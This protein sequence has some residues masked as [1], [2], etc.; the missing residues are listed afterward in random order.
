MQHG[1]SLMRFCHLLVRVGCLWKI[2]HFLELPEEKYFLF[3]K[4]NDGMFLDLNWTRAMICF[5][6]LKGRNKHR[7]GQSGVK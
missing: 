2:Q 5:G 1:W 4:L 6:L 7:I 3:A